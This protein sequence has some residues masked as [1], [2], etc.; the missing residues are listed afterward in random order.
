MMEDLFSF[1]DR[2]PNSPGYRMR[3]TSKEAAARV[4]KIP[5][6]YDRILNALTEPMTFYDMRDKLGLLYSRVQPRMSDLA[7]QGKIKDS[8][9]RKQ[10]PYGRNAILWEKA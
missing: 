4:T 7:A 10:T 6:I 2:Y 1:R 3:E 9:Q 5:E 8:G